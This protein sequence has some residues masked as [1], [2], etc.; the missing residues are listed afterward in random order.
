M[1]LR[2]VFDKFFRRRKNRAAESDRKNNP[3]NIADK[4]EF[5]G[6]I[7]E[8]GAFCA[9]HNGEAI[10]HLSHI[11]E[12]EHY[13]AEYRNKEEIDIRKNREFFKPFEEEEF[14]D[15]DESAEPKTPYN[16]VPA[17]AVPEAGKEPDDEEVEILVLSVSA[18]GN[19]DIVP[20]ESAQGHM[21][22]SPE[23]R[24]GTGN[25]GIVEVFEEME[26]KDFSKTDCHIGITG[27]IVINLNREHQNAEPYRRGAFCG[28]VAGK[29]CF[30]KLT[31]CV[32]DENFFGKTD[33]ES[34]CAAPDILEVFPA[35]VDLKG[36][37]RVSY[38]RTRN[39][40]GIKRNVH[41]EFHIVMLRFDFS[42]VNVNG[43]AEG[44]EGIEADTDRK[45]EFRNRKFKTC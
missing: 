29:I 24:C 9:E 19:I 28:K 4:S 37:V 34:C 27:E 14:F 45:S 33:E 11:L 2:A 38:D 31:G 5:E 16:E 43:V 12:I 23:F 7:P 44:L 13:P 26:S 39:K 3:E 40:L 41:E 8:S 35:V 18:K 42:A 25:I 6:D 17:C 21:P 20:E 30:G 32:R 1:E 15:N 22:S 10:E 36:N